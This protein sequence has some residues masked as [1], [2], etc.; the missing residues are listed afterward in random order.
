MG[1]VFRRLEKPTLFGVLAGAALLAW[2]LRFV[3]DDAYISWR[4][5]RN[6]ADGYGL[7]WNVG[8]RVEGYTNFLWTLIAAIPLALGLRVEPFMLV[9]GIACFVASLFFFRQ[10]VCAFR[11]G[12]W[13]ALLATATLATFASFVWFATGGLETPLQT[14]LCLAVACQCVSDRPLDQR[15][16][17]G[18]GVL[19]ALVCATRLDSVL[20]VA[21]PFLALG[22]HL[23]RS[24]G[25]PGLHRLLPAV[26]VSAALIG[27][28]FAWK[29]GFYGTIVPNTLRAKVDAEAGLLV[30]RGLTY[31]LAFAR[32]YEFAL[33][34]VFLPL[35]VWRAFVMASE[36]AVSSE[37]VT[38]SLTATPILE[39]MP[40]GYAAIALL[41]A[42]FLWLVYL[43]RVG[44]D[45]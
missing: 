22:V 44:G 8:E 40:D 30:Q 38:P 15:R 42:I 10:I 23:Y 37:L 39:I 18:L 1:T 13:I 33:P 12:P 6:L 21:P 45:F 9:L 25:R 14:L 35:G 26:E 19:V 7:V 36:Q 17:A 4:F 31:L 24:Q 41:T 43:I 16:S 11:V 2:R 3:C 5:A 34:L 32:S 27:A 20:L 28:W 29:V